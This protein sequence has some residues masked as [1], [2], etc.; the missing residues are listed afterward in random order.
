MT[1]HQNFSVLTVELIQPKFVRLY[2]V[3]ILF[4]IIRKKF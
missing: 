1:N 4:R 2:D 3:L